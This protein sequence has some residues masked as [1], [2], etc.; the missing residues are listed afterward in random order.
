MPKDSDEVPETY[1]PYAVPNDEVREAIEV[2]RWYSL[3][4]MVTLI[5]ALVEGD[6]VQ[7]VTWRKGEPEYD[8]LITKDSYED[9]E[10]ISLEGSAE[11]HSKMYRLWPRWEV[12]GDDSFTWLRRQLEGDS[13]SRGEIKEM[14]VVERGDGETDQKE[15]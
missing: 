11:G 14:K 4:D 5:R 3:T 13:E 7:V 2:G 8:L 6:K 1:L 10:A 15:A 12:R 9:K